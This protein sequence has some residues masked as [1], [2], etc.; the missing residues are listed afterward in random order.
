MAQVA[1]VAKIPAAPGKR[2][3]LVKAMQVAL[4]SAA[5]EAGTTYY[6]LHTD[7]KDADALWM[8]ELYTDRDALSAHMGSDSFKAL[9]PVISPFLG[10]APELTVMTPVGGKGL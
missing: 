5:D 1:V 7:D 10:G 9:V 8:Y 6:I 3:E 2:D 4:D